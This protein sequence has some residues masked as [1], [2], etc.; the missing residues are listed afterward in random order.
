MLRLWLTAITI[1]L[2]SSVALAQADVFWQQQAI[3]F[4]Q[5]YELVQSPGAENS[6]F[7]SI[8]AHAET[9]LKRY[10]PSEWFYVSVG[11]SGA[12]IAADLSVMSEMNSEI[13]IKTLAWSSLRENKKYLEPAVAQFGDGYLR[14]YLPRT[15]KKILFIDYTQTGDSIVAL[16]SFLQDIYGKGRFGYYLMLSP[17]NQIGLRFYLHRRLPRPLKMVTLSHRDLFYKALQLQG[18]D[19]FAQYGRFPL[20]AA[21]SDFAGN[22][23]NVRLEHSASYEEFIDWVRYAHDTFLPGR[24]AVVRSCRAIFSF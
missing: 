19:T 5:Q 18:L 17:E 9:I 4:L 11:R 12:A 13:Q 21:Y 10:P 1:Y 14:A 7:R 16:N 6:F 2:T 15:H 22:V 3:G 20:R 24:R 23:A 8:H